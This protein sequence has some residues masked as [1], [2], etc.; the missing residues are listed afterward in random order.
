MLKI[1]MLRSFFC[2]RRSV[3]SSL[4]LILILTS[5]FSVHAQS[6]QTTQSDDT[7]SLSFTPPPLR[8]DTGEPGDRIE[9]GTR[10]G[11][12][13]S[14]QNS[15]EKQ[16]TALVPMYE[17]SH[18]KLVLGTTASAYPTLWFYVPQASTLPAKLILQEKEK[19]IFE[20]PVALTKAPGIIK[21]A[22]PVTV[23]LKIGHKY[24]WF[25]NV[26]CRPDQPPAF[27]HGWIRRDNLSPTLALQLRKAT[28]KKRVALLAANGFWYDALSAASELRAEIKNNYWVSL[29]KTVGLSSVATEPMVFTASQSKPTTY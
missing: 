9:Q 26:Y 4:S 1:F 16:L 21:V 24:H 18:S 14:K 27:V 12:E 25:F 22:M 3:V 11:C 13:N 28:L 17:S 6:D 2:G 29:L 15:K 5:C 23:P 20:T 10:S 8:Q 7:E 19:T